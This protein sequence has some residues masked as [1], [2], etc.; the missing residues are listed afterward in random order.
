MSMMDESGFLGSF[1]AL[2]PA[3]RYYFEVFGYAL[4]PDTLTREECQTLVGVLREIRA[5]IEEGRPVGDVQADRHDGYFV[6]LDRFHAAHPALTAYLTKPQLV[7]IAEEVCGGP[8]RLNSC[9]AIFNR[10]PPAD[11]LPPTARFHVSVQ[12]PWGT[13]TANGLFHTCMLRLITNLTDVG[14]DD[15]GTRFVVGSHKLDVPLEQV[16]AC[17]EADTGLVHQVVAPAGTTVLFSES[18]VHATGPIQSDHER[19]VITAAY[20][21]TM[22]QAWDGMEPTAEAIAA[23]PA[24]L[25]PF[26]TGSMAWWWS[27]RYRTFD[28]RA[29]T[30]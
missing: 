8:V 27:N 19:V 13:W 22:Y 23:V 30:L 14:P 7:G 28:T 11:E 4:L 18:T 15:G 26:L 21:P 16:I 9:Y 1:P 24:S 25:R 12:P 2:T 3:Q 17:A 10:R 29:P 20:T 6:G 5:E